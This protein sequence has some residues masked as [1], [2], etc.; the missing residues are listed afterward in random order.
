MQRRAEKIV[1]DYWCRGRYLL[2]C[3]YSCDS[4]VFVGCAADYELVELPLFLF[5]D[6]IHANSITLSG[7]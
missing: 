1:E 6:N 5:Q 4:T 3:W 2:K 7:P